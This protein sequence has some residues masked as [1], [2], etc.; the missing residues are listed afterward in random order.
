MPVEH[1]RFFPAS[2]PGHRTRLLNGM[3]H[4]LLIGRN[5]CHL[6]ALLTATILAVPL[7]TLL[8]LRTPPSPS[9]LTHM[10][11]SIHPYADELTS[12]AEAAAHR[13]Y[14]PYSRFFVGAAVLLDNG[15]IVSGCNVENASYR[16]TTC[17]EQAAIVSAVAQHGPPIR[18]LAVAVHNLNQ[19][20]CQPCGA[21]RQTIAEF[22]SPD[23][24]VF[25]PG[26][27]GPTSCTL[28]DLLPSTFQLQTAR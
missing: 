28:A 1:F 2:L 26:P 18:I 23:A 10:L 11:P 13:A 9:N 5:L 17:A 22:A 8:V 16:L 6:R 14:A 4:I 3:L 15:N 7:I 24:V 19:T 27:D 20:A 21:C 25:Y 12:Q